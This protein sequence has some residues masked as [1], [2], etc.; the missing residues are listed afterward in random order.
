MPST[1]KM[2]SSGSLHQATPHSLQNGH[3]TI[4]TTACYPLPSQH[5]HYHCHAILCRNIIITI[6]NVITTLS[7]WL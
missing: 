2:I 4:T 7:S 1:T 6:T 5:N 3:N